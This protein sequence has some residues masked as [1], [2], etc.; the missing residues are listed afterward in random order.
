MA[1]RGVEARYGR[2][3]GRYVRI[4][5][6]GSYSSVYMHLSR[7][8]PNA[9]VG[10]EIRQGDIIG[11]VGKSGNATGYH[12][13]YGLE[14]AGRYVDP[15][16]IQFPTAEPVPTNEWELFASQRGEWLTVLRQGQANLGLQIAGAGGM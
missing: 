9:K 8:H 7:F 15:I 6:G 11:Y 12:L 2:E 4:R 16:S 10:V 13:H 3:P 1:Y 14:Q 5:H